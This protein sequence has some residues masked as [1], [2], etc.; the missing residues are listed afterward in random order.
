[1]GTGAAASHRH[2][3]DH[4]A[5]GS[6][7]R[8]L[9]LAFLLTAAILVLEAA[10]GWV[11][12]SLA[13]LA[14]AGHILTD[15]FALG[16]AWFAVHQ[17]RR[18]ADSVRTYGYHRVGILTAMVN[19]VTLIAVVAAIGYEAVR[20]LQHPVPVRGLLVIAAALAAIAINALIAL[21][22][23]E[24]RDLNVRA[25]LLHVVGD[26]A[27]S[28]G[29]VAAGTVVLLT[30]WLY[31][32][33]LISLG[34]GAL[35]AFGAVGVVRTAANVLLEGTPPGIDLEAVRAE[36]MSGGDVASVHDLHVWSLS[37]VETALSCHVVV[38]EGT[39]AGAE[40]TVR[41]LEG[42]LCRRFGIGHTTIQL[43]R[44]QPCV[45]DN[46]H[47]PGQH[48]HPHPPATSGR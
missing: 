12:N 35:I 4:G 27:A 2:G 26:L 43:E 19:A 22:L 13:L 5:S 30:G 37:S 20:R 8:R 15:V 45:G 40:G 34:V 32:D 28:I 41:G 23:R 7:G 31:A 11:A 18:P 24:G 9:R 25:A 3:E 46:G 29:V 33:P 47:G 10:A 36:I 48:N 39:L 1:M 42:R 17:A 16:L 44:S 21:V 6:M 14:D 38:D